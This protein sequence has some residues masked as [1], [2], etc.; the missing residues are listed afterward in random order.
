MFFWPRRHPER[1]NRNYQNN[2]MMLAMQ[3][4]LACDVRESAEK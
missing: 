1:R 2:I 3:A 4:K